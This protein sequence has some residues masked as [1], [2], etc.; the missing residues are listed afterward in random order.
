MQT[1][2]GKECIALKS[3]SEIGKA[4]LEKA[5]IKHSYQRAAIE[6]LLDQGFIVAYRA[7]GQPLRGNAWKYKG[8]YEESLNRAISRV[9]AALPAEYDIRV[10]KCGVKGGFGYWIERR[11]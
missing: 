10:G 3:D 1:E 11:Y 4:I 2:N 5:Q 9:R 6:N 8:K 7:T